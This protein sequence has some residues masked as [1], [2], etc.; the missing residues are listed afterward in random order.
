MTEQTH[1]PARQY[2]ATAK[3]HERMAAAFAAAGKHADSNAAKKAAEA[4]YESA[5]KAA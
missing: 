2:L 5:R 1:V 3:F 4:C